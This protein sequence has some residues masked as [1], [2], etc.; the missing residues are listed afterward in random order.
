MADSDVSIGKVRKNA[1]AGAI[2]NVMEWYD[3]A[4]YAY[5]A[6]VIGQLFFP[7]ND[8]FTS[9]LA[10]YG[11]FAVGYLSRPL[12]ALVFG[13]IGDKVG[14][15]LVLILSV[16][17]MGITTVSIGL[18]PDVGQ[19]GPLAAVF[20]IALRILQGFSVGGEYTGST[21]FIVEYAP[22]N[23]RAFYASWVLCGAFGGFLLGSAV[24][25]L[26]NNL[27]DQDAL[28]TWGWRLPFLAGALIALVAMLLRRHIEEPPAPEYE[29]EWQRSPVV[30]AFTEHWRDML[31][32]M[33]LA[34]AINV[35]FYMMFV[36][37]V[38][39]LTDRMHVSTAKALDIN[40]ICM[41]VIT[42]LPLAFALMADRI[43]RKPILLS[44]IIGII[45]F[46]WPLFWLMHHT[47]TVLILLGQLGFT[48]L[49]SCV[50]AANIATQAE[51]VPH[52]VRVSVLSIS[53]NFCLSL[54]G[55]TTPLV[56]T[57]LV[58]RTADDFAPVYYLMAL[59]V[60]SLITVL[61][62]PET[63]GKSMLE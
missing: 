43:G 12:G 11:T 44:G 26:L 3:F 28:Q 34:L 50:Y 1:F 51:I 21:T 17:L 9:L 5:M 61:L 46:S 40:T 6:P 63:R 62:I 25:T 55:G 54:F 16:S 47:D 29:E 53:Y 39:Y 24:S 48:V 49:F 41:A 60:L 19:I 20:L 22:R 4:V 27:L 36:Y 35:G 31:K 52:R 59:S 56:A 30:V 45:V 58:E 2:G 7:S 15:K 8:D 33:G 38:G 37:A 10:T 14:R 32:V 23:R 18:L 13:H 57:Y 42:F